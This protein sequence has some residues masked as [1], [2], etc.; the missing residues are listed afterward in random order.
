MRRLVGKT[1][2]LA[3]GIDVVSLDELG[4]RL[5]RFNFGR[6]ALADEAAIRNA[7]RE[8]AQISDDVAR[9]ARLGASF[10]WSEWAEIV[11]PWQVET[12]EAY[13]DISRLGRK[14]R[15]SEPQRASAWQLFARV[16]DKLRADGMMTRAEMFTK[17]A[18]HYATGAKSPFEHVVVDEAQDL[19]VP[20]LRFLASLAAQRPNGLFFAGDLGQRIFQ[21]PFSWKALG[22]D[23]RG[24]SR[25]L[26]VNYRTSHQI[27]LRADRLLGPEIADVDG[28]TE[29]RRGTVSVFNGPP[30]LVRT[31]PDAEAEISGVAGWLNERARAGIRPGEMA[32]FVRSEDELPRARAALVKSALPHHVL[33]DLVDT[34]TEEVS[35]GTMHLAKGLEFRAV[36]VMA[37]DDEVVPKQQRID[38]VADE[39]DLKE[40]YDTERHLLY[41]ALTRARDRLLVT[42]IEPASEFL[43]D[44]R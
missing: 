31:F 4:E 11:D 36:A 15:L 30:P 39:A 16:R 13:R 24:R 40:V 28:N 8:A 19:G 41:V 3:E 2:M 14:T 44:I 12:W 18:A 1:P 17:L 27:R 33:D 21:T 32:V 26:T 34:D 35:I 7:L 38:N 6:P 10:L 9:P 37:C 23:V 20:Q 25:I 5:H 22:V 43:Q 42:S 29:G